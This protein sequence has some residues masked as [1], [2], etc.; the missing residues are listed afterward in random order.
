MH[1]L[2]RKIAIVGENQH[3]FG[4]R[5][6]AADVVEGVQRDGKEAVNCIPAEFVAAGANISAWLVENDHDLFFRE[7]AFAVD[8]DAVGFGHACGKFDAGCAVDIDPTCG[9]QIIASAT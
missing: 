9:D 1:E 8:A 3:A 2:L 5:I 6:E 7:N 4:I